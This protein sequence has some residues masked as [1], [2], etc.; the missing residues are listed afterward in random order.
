MIIL[1]IN[2]S[3]ARLNFQTF[4]EKVDYDGEDM[5]YLIESAYL[6]MDVLTPCFDALILDKLPMLRF[7]PN[8]L[9]TNIQKFNSFYRT[10]APMW[11]DRQKVNIPFL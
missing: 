3:I 4:G 7:L 5:T 9:W 6:N 8:K 1:I 11:I 10:W 2:Q